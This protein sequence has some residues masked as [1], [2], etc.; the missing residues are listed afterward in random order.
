[1]YSD[2]KKKFYSMEIF[3]FY[4]SD[5][6][7]K[8]IKFMVELKTW[9]IGFLRIFVKTIYDNMRSVPYITPF[10]K[11]IVSE[12]IFRKEFQYYI[13]EEDDKFSAWIE[14]LS[15]QYAE[16]SSVLYDRRKVIETLNTISRN[17]KNSTPPLVDTL[18]T[19]RGWHKIS[20]SPDGSEITSDVP[21]IP[22]SDYT[23]DEFVMV[24]ID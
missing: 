24:R 1:M 5:I 6:Y 8:Y 19:Q 4:F 11:P 20:I 13:D 3:S 15:P 21:F 9:E 22:L 2:S 10:G 16:N 7:V 12:T 14:Q 23:G 18:P 17:F